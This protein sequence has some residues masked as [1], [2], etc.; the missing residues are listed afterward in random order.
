MVIVVPPIEIVLSELKHLE[1]LYIQTAGL[2]MD[3]KLAEYFGLT[4]SPFGVPSEHPLRKV[5]IV[6]SPSQI[7]RTTWAYHRPEESQPWRQ[8]VNELVEVL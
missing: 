6:A 5:V 2:H 1:E 4:S 7:I 8:V 3:E